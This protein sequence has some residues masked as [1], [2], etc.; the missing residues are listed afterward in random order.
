MVG[1]VYYTF[2]LCS[3]SRSLSG[4]PD[5]LDRKG[6]YRRTS[7]QTLK[8]I[9]HDSVQSDAKA[10]QALLE[11]RGVQY[12]YRAVGCVCCTHLDGQPN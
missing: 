7:F 6:T 3:E 10:A 9:C 12:S 1:K 11:K 8:L 2:Q 5:A 4:A